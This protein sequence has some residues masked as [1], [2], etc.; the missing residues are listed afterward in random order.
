[1]SHKIT[2]THALKDH[3]H[4][5][6]AIWINRDTL[7]WE[8]INAPDCSCAL[9]YS[10]T[11]ELAMQETGLQGGQ[12][13][14][15]EPAPDAPSQEFIRD[16]PYL[17]GWLAYRI[18]AAS[19]ERIPEILQCEMAFAVRDAEGHLADIAG[20]QVAGVLDA[21]YDYDGPLGLTWEG[22]KPVL[23]V[24]APTA[25]NVQL[26]LYSGP[27]TEEE[28]VLPMTADPQTGVWSILGSADWAGYYY[29]FDLRLYVPSTGK[30]AAN[31][32]TDP[33]SLSLST[34]SLRS[35]IVDLAD[36]ALQPAGWAQLAKP[37]LAA[38]E[39]I[40]IYELHLRDFSIYD[41]TVPTPL[42]GTYA[43][44]TQPQSD[45]MRHLTR[46][47]EAGITHLHLLPVFDISTINEERAAWKTPDEEAL[48]AFPPDSERQAAII[49]AVRHLDGYNWGYD[50]CHYT[51]PEGSYA[52]DPVGMPR[53]LEFREMV[54][55]LNRTGLRVV[56]DVVYN[57][58]TEAGQ[59]PKSVLDKIVPGYYH[60]LSAQGDLETS[61]CCANTASE[62]HMM[63]K[64][65]V[66][67]VLTWAK[68]YKVDGFRFDLMGHHMLRS[69]RAVRAALDDLTLARDGVDGKAIYI[70][71]EGWDLGEVAGGARG[72]NATQWNIAGTGIG[73]FNDRLRDGV[74][75]GSPM[76][77]PR[78]QGFCT[79][80]YFS[81]NAACTQDEAACR[82][83]LREQTLWIHT[84]L[85]AGLRDYLHTRAD[86]NPL[87]GD[88]IDYKGAPAGY[89]LAPRETIN[90]VAA[91]DNETLFDAI[92]IKAAETVSLPDRIR[93]NNLALSFPMFAQ[94]I[95]FFH[96][97]DDILR[98]KSLERNSFDSGDWFNRIDW[99]LNDNNWGRGLPPEGRA[100][101]DAFRPL[102]ANPALKPSPAEIRRSAAIFRELL[103]IRKSS[104][105]FRLRSA[106]QIRACLT[107]I[108]PEKDLPGLIGMRLVDRFN[109]DAAHRELV[110]WFNARPDSAR[111]SA[112]VLENRAYR[113]HPV[114]RKSVDKVVR[115]ASYLPDGGSFVIPPLTAAV[116]V[117]PRR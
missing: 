50:P 15:L 89:A 41:Q 107:F 103:R 99:T 69:M 25:Q 28:A 55:A 10:Y 4:R 68:A 97:G 44:F 26:V 67:S 34:N 96:A 88:E 87:R 62:H 16:N 82:N 58:T 104:P 75:G 72:V 73:A 80:A 54:A 7:L 20:V 24:W 31:R 112:L 39:D 8:N 14:P 38:P 30:I 12:E 18:P 23:R 17:S 2:T 115:H 117:L 63:E 35:Q 11:A 94:G 40:V 71:G 74:R 46:L 61:T 110:I 48:A 90:Y 56:M 84:G 59:S 29:H 42:R 114:L 21:L 43:A 1:M 33:Y 101:W 92:Q 106:E 22:G 98:S 100:Y 81:P 108:Q 116:F 95:P 53:I 86:G 83:M 6:R 111:P 76:G 66:D 5:R 3:L 52:S 78:G 9:L 13:I 102:L 45:G 113:L 60:R 36:T 27:T 85:A 65:M 37:A 49:Q 91:H 64:L 51:V 32:V 70:Y 79:G 77:D 105:L 57:H 19:L 109:L 93:A 47:A